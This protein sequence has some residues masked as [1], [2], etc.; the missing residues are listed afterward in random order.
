MRY[1]VAATLLLSACGGGSDFQ[2]AIVDQSASGVAYRK[3]PAR[4]DELAKVCDTCLT[5]SVQDS[6]S[7]TVEIGVAAKNGEGCVAKFEDES[8][9]TAC[10]TDPCAA[11]ADVCATCR[12]SDT[13]AACQLRVKTS[14]A[15]VGGPDLNFC[16]EGV[17]YYSASCSN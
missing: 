17:E 13:K 12:D 14:R 9:Q 8:F 4:C 6:C 10:N 7:Q 5:Q 11:L 1:V 16:A 2:K 15:T 3:D